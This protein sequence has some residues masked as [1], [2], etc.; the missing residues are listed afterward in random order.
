MNRAATAISFPPA[1]HYTERVFFLQ[2]ADRYPLRLSSAVLFRGDLEEDL[3]MDLWMSDLSQSQAP[4]RL[5]RIL[6]GRVDSDFKV[7][8]LGAYLY[9]RAEQNTEGVI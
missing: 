7:D 8:S 9:Y 6:S 1:S 5:S 2:P 4:R 3:K